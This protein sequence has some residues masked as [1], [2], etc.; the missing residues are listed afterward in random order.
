MAPLL[1]AATAVTE[2]SLNGAFA[3]GEAFSALAP[4]RDSLRSLDAL[5]LTH[6]VRSHERSRMRKGGGRN[7]ERAVVLEAHGL[8]YEGHSRLTSLRIMLR[9]S[10]CSL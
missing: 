3:G 7:R 5:G 1:R 8:C 2:L 6:E 9:A 4:M 10:A